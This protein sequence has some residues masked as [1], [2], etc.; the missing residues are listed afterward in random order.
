MLTLFPFVLR[1]VLKGGIALFI[2]GIPVMAQSAFRTNGPHQVN[3]LSGYITDSTTRQPLSGA[4]VQFTDLKTGAITNAEGY[5]LIKNI[6]A[7]YHSLEVSFIGYA[8]LTLQVYINGEQ[9]IHFALQPSILENNEVIVTGVSTGVQIRRTP[10]PV[11]QIKRQELSHATA[12]NLVDLLA[13]KPGISQYTTGPAI[14][15]PVIRGLGG[16]RVVVLN[17]GVRQEGQQWGDE[18]GLEL[19]EYS[20]QKVELL[21]GPASLIYGSDALAGVIQ[22][23]THVP[24]PQGTLKGAA[25]TQYQ[26]NN[27]M[28]GGGL[29]LGAHHQYGFN[30]NT[31]VSAKAASDYRNRYDGRVYNSKFREANFGGYAGWNRPWGYSHLIIGSFNQKAGI[32]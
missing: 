22:V 13:H 18:H 12:S 26:S 15:K 10:T 21:K 29:Q 24:V 17:D 32:I 19:D 8:T 7:G 14:S 20:V 16:N 25:T 5:Y 28:R 27:R 4:S 6:P 3:S 1:W 9:H 23:F 31:Y 30:W 11:A 2:A